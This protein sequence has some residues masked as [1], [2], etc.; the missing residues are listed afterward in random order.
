MDKTAL[1]EQAQK[2]NKISAK[3]AEEIK[4]SGQIAAVLKREF[5]AIAEQIP[6]LRATALL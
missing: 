1:N 6:E 4:V 5:A 3:R 2:K